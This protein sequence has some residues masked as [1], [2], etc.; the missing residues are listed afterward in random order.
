[1]YFMHPSRV[2]SKALST[3]WL[4]IR[5]KR[6]FFLSYVKWMWEWAKPTHLIKFRLEIH[7]IIKKNFLKF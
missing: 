3:V 7:S 2:T 6:S 1:M 5:S 4:D